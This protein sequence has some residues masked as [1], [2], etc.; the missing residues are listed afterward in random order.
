[1]SLSK[2]ATRQ[3]FIDY[4][5]RRLGAPV[6]EINVDDLQLEDCVEE[7]LEYYHDFHYDAVEKIYLKHQVTAQNI[8][9][10][11]IEVPEAVIGIYNIFPINQTAS[12]T[13]NLFNAVYQL[14]L[15]DL[16]DL[17]STSV[18]YFTQ[19]MQYLQLI[20]TIINGQ[21]PIRFNRHTNRLYIDMDWSNA[22]EPGRWIIVETYRYLDP[23]DMTNVWNDM[24]LKKYAAAL[25]KKQWATNLKKFSGIQLPGG[26]T[27]DGDKLYQ[28]AT[29]EIAQLEK[30]AQDTWS[31]PPDFMIG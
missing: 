1:M 14:R 8:Q 20:D 26:V 21:K 11:Y 5:L 4:C 12:N 24:W 15:N 3:E 30:E 17:T 28:E 27:L 2:P 31:L 10:G 6:V 25:M 23:N 9:D 16:Y 18:L 29:D 19:T 22:I 7:A 13:D